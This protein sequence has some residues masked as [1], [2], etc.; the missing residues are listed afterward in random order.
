MSSKLSIIIFMFPL[1]IIFAVCATLSAASAPSTASVQAVTLLKWRVIGAVDAAEVATT[2]SLSHG[3]IIRSLSLSRSRHV[4][5]F[6]PR[7]ISCCV[8]TARR[9]AGG[10]SGSFLRTGVCVSR[11]RP[12]TRFVVAAQQR[13]RRR[14]CVPSRSNPF[15]S[16]QPRRPQPGGLSSASSSGEIGR[17]V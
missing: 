11:F 8:S 14:Q 15:L 3:I 10:V 16:C 12:S 13:A 4:W 2:F 1:L 5:L 17:R 7:F 9:P 6:F